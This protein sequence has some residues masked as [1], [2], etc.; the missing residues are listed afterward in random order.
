MVILKEV[1][2]WM[3]CYNNP[4]GS[5]MI[6]NL[7]YE[8]FFSSCVR[9]PSS[10]TKVINMGNFYCNDKTDNVLFRFSFVH[11]S[12]PPLFR[13]YV[14][15]SGAKA[16]LVFHFVSYFQCPHHPFPVISAPAS[17][18]GSIRDLR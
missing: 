7:A 15:R 9:L 13:A 10:Y 5:V 18:S 4:V 17:F 2:M 3:K 12:F 1:I 8:A 6:Y 14:I 16:N 11:I